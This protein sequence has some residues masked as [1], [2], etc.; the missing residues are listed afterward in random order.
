MQRCNSS[1]RW[2]RGKCGVHSVKDEEP[3][4]GEDAPL[5]LF[6]PKQ[7][8][9]TYKKRLSK[10]PPRGWGLGSGSVFAPARVSPS[11][12][13][14]GFPL[15]PWLGFSFARALGFPPPGAPSTSGSVSPSLKGSGFPLPQ[16]LGFAPLS[17][18]ASASAKPP[19]PWWSRWGS[20]GSVGSWF[21]W[22]VRGKV[23]S[24]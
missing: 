10:A 11:L 5:F 13:G 17:G 23:R 4:Q 6:A 7:K 16:G 22:C 3:H 20:P 14:S 1:V 15:P 18:L 8:R 9:K 21:W 19:P 24:P 12:L 2:F